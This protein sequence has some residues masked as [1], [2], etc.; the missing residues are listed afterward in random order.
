MVH[1]AAG[2]GFDVLGIVRSPPQRPNTRC[3]YVVT[4]LLDG[5]ATRAVVGEA[6]EAG[7]T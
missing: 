4:D 3:T 5:A 7:S 1:E 6:R 2:L